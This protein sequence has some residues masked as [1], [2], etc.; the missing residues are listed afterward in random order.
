MLPKRCSCVTPNAHEHQGKAM[1]CQR[2]LQDA[3]AHG[4]C[5]N[6]VC[7]AEGA[8]RAPCAAVH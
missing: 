4:G 1:S 5:Q 7:T 6:S 2:P 3:P 8:G